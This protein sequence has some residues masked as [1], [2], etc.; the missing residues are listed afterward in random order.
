MN[1]FKEGVKRNAGKINL[2]KPLQDILVEL[3][4]GNITKKEFMAQTGIAD[5]KTVERKIEEIVV[6][7]PS[8]KTLYDEYI[9]KKSTNYHGYN[10]RAEAIS[11]LRSDNSQSVMAKKL[12]ISRRTF[13]TKMKN[14]Q[15]ANMDNI[16]GKLLKCHADRKMK[17][18]EIT[19]EELI[20]INLELDKYEEEFPVGLARY[21]ERN[22][23]EVRLENLIRIIE[24]VDKL[25]EE[26]LTIKEISQRGIISE[27]NY[28]KYKAEAE[29]LTNILKEK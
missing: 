13:S 19:P 4:K 23:Q 25:K 24:T 21:E 14:L 3:M 8:L 20:Q 29:N 2:D 12:G 6:L 17:R 11:M 15:E 10:F 9:S 7:N 26:G 5:K 28:R 16:L 22:P 27:S 18:Q 1:D